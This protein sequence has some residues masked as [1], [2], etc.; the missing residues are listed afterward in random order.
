MGRLFLVFLGIG[1]PPEFLEVERSN[2]LVMV[3]IIDW[4]IKVIETW[5]DY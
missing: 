2:N 4:N 5:G 1:K 3:Y